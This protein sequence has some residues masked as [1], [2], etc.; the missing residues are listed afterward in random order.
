MDYTDVL[1]QRIE[2]RLEAKT[3]RRK[4]IDEIMKHFDVSFDDIKKAEDLIDARIVDDPLQYYFL[5]SCIREGR[6][7]RDIGF[8]ET[9]NYFEAV[10]EKAES[11]VPYR[12]YVI[13][14]LWVE[15]HYETEAYEEIGIDSV[16]LNDIERVAQY[17]LYSY[18][19]KIIF[20]FGGINKMG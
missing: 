2:G 17:Q 1:R 4:I 8:T 13:Y 5:G 15:F 11:V 10:K 14:R 20:D 16:D 9:D 12:T 7:I 3:G 18:A 19:E 6:E